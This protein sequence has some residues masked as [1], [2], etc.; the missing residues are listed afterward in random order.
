VENDCERAP[1]VARRPSGHHRPTLFINSHGEPLTR[2]GFVHILAQ[3]VTSATRTQPSLAAKRV[4]PHVLRHT[5]AMHTLEATGDIRK[6][7]LWLGHAT[8]ADARRRA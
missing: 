7:A 1:G 8:L 4:S 2:G 6:V 5:C 3:H